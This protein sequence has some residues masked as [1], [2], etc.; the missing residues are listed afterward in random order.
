L[1]LNGFEVT[2]FHPSLFQLQSW[3]PNLSIAP[4]P[5]EF[6]PY[7]NEAEAIFIFLE[8]S[9]RMQ[10]ILSYA[11]AH[12][13]KKTTVLNPIA[14]ANRDYP[15][16]EQGQFDGTK[17]FVDNLYAFCKRKFPVTTKS[18]GITPPAYLRFRKEARRVLIHPTSSRPNKNWDKEKF[19]TLASALK[20]R[21]Y[22]PEW[23]LSEKER[24]EWDAASF[25]APLFDSLNTLAHYIYES[26]FLIG[27]DSGP[28]HLSSCLN[29]PTMTLFCNKKASLFWRPG[30]GQVTTLC[31]NPWV[32]N[33]KGIRLRD[34]FWQKWIS[35]ER[36]L[37]TFEGSLIKNG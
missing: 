31:P 33:L 35:V 8:K 18:N 5:K 14:T 34:K 32:P 30:W 15:F 22:R 20:A 11:L 26:G 19:I 24:K 23:L 9:P 17:S 37:K 16:W 2:T 10:Q 7:L 36:V 6:I 27:N 1:Q 12:H 25:P 29:I 3:F 4:S 13:G 21:G 28:G